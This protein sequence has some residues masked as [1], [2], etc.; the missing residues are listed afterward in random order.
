M[1]IEQ[2]Q[3]ALNVSSSIEQGM[4]NI[5]NTLVNGMKEAA[6]MMANQ[7]HRQ[8]KCGHLWKMGDNDGNQP[9]LWL[10]PEIEAQNETYV[11]AYYLQDDNTTTA[12]TTKTICENMKW[13]FY[14]LSL[15]TKIQIRITIF[16]LLA[17][18]QALS[19]KSKY[20]NS[21]S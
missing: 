5:V 7:H 16:Y 21:R 3:A 13:C 15:Q 18:H 11:K 4:R 10:T 6:E 9:E 2:H 8:W 14:L 17:L 1:M 19:Q 12:K 20:Q